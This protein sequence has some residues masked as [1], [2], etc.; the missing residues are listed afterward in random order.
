MICGNQRILL[1]W[2]SVR[3][4]LSYYD[5]GKIGNASRTAGLPRAAKLVNQRL[6]QDTT[7]L[8]NHSIARVS[9]QRVLPPLP[10]LIHSFIHQR[11]RYHLAVASHVFYP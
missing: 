10:L 1:I 7:H 8:R 4:L 9:R 6:S 3:N 5:G 2:P 11:R